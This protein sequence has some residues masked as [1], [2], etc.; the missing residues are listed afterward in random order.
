MGRHG[1]KRF[2]E[3]SRIAL[4][5]TL[6]TAA[7]R[8]EREGWCQGRGYEEGKRCVTNALGVAAMDVDETCWLELCSDAT[9]A[10]QEDLGISRGLAQWN[11]QPERTVEEVTAALR[12]VASQ[13]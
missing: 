6:E 11:D 4:I 2:E 10:V 12:R 3:E 9:V 5:R 13:L 7:F 8:L 1:S